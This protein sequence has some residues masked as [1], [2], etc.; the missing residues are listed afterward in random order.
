MPS[1]PRCVLQ[2][3]KLVEEARL[4][5]GRGTRLDAGEAR[6]GGGDP[7]AGHRPF[8]L[9]SI[10][11][12]ISNAYSVG[13]SLTIG[14]TKPLTKTA[15]SSASVVAL[16]SVLWLS[17]RALSRPARADQEWPCFPRGVTIDILAAAIE[18][19]R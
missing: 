8:H 3:V 17:Q 6:T 1:G 11:R 5:Y 18:S 19:A 2:M 15:F 12:F 7:S 13:S 4:C 9:H 16:V 14:S 10:R